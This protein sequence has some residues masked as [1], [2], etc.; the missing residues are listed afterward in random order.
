MLSPGAQAHAVLPAAWARRVVAWSP[1]PP[2]PACV[3][4]PC[5]DSALPCGCVAVVPCVPHGCSLPDFTPA[6][7]PV[8]SRTTLCDARHRQVIP[9]WD[10][11]PLIG[12]VRVHPSTMTASKLPQTHP[13]ALSAS[14]IP[15]RRARLGGDD[16]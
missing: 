16:P 2:H 3:S 7:G 5:R 9:P 12:A 11:I 10:N 4:S 14:K 8:S 13:S 6:L 1:L 15:L